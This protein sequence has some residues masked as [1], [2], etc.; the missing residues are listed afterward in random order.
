[1]EEAQEDDMPRWVPFNESGTM[2]PPDPDLVDEI[3][4]K[5]PLPEEPAPDTGKP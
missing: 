2:C 5:H 1:M 4:A 3:L